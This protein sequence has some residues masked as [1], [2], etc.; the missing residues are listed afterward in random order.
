MDKKE[1]SDDFISEFPI[2]QYLVVNIKIGWLK[3]T[4]IKRLTLLYNRLFVHFPLPM[5]ICFTF[6]A[7]YIFCSYMIAVVTI[8]K[9]VRAR[10]FYVTVIFYSITLLLFISLHLSVIID[11]TSF[12]AVTTS[13]FSYFHLHC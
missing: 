1:K 12:Y 2:E 3:K 13:P 10:L 8:A 5:I 11:D 6:F 9:A 4:S 7:A